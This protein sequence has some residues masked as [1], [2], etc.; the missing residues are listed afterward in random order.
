M[1]LGP[2][3]SFYLLLFILNVVLHI[4]FQPSKVLRSTAKGAAVTMREQKS[5]LLL[6]PNCQAPNYCWFLRLLEL[7]EPKR[8][9]L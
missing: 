5:S 8:M 3:C 1:N 2:S 9:S 4:A 6:W 7:P